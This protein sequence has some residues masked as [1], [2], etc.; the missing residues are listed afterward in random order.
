VSTQVA[1]IAIR[2]FEERDEAAVLALLDRTLGGGPA[3]SR[4]SAFFRWK[5]RE[6]PFGVSYMLVAESGG[7]RIVGLRAFMRWRFTAPSGA[8][9]RAVRAVDTATHP[10]FQGRG[11]FSLLTRRALE[12]LQDEADLV[13]NTPNGQSLPG[14]LKMGWRTVGSVPIRIRPLRAIRFARGARHV[15]DADATASMPAV[16][17]PPASEVLGDD[18]LAAMLRAREPAGGLATPRDADYLRWR[19]GAAPLLGYRAI[20][21]DAGKRMDGVAVFRVR[22]RGRLVEGTLAELIVGDE[23]ASTARALVRGVRIASCADHLAATFPSGSAASNAVRRSGFVRA[24]GGMTLVV[25]TL[26]HDLAPDPLDLRAWALSIGDLE[27]F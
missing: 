12:E 20:R 25:N 17:A 10:D 16:E 2:R 26:G 11:I 7:D 14:Y 6:N 23:R 3:G 9:V 13:F 22:P 19:Y 21:I 5:H 27:V 8:T 18:G 1:G 15:R 4:P 24:P